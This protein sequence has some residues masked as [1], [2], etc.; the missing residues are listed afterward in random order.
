MSSFRTSGRGVRIAQVGTVRPYHGTVG[1]TVVFAYSLTFN[2]NGTLVRLN[3]KWVGISLLLAPPRTIPRNNMMK[4]V[5]ALNLLA[6]GAALAFPSDAA[7]HRINPRTPEGLRD[8]LQRTGERL[9]MVSAHR[10]GPMKGFL[11]NCLATF[12]NTLQHTFSLMEIDPPRTPSVSIAR[13]SPSEAG[14]K[15][16]PEHFH[17]DS[18]LPSDSVWGQ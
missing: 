5:I 18:L 9:P 3:R 8:L 2:V 16:R 1:G 10:G 17:V 12:S 14:A 15:Q 7:Q 11:E 13:F 4:P 6:L